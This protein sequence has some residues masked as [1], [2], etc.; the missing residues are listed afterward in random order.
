MW[1]FCRDPVFLPF[2][3]PC[4]LTPSYPVT[5]DCWSMP[6]VLCVVILSTKGSWT[7]LV[8]WAVAYPCRCS[9]IRR[10]RSMNVHKSLLCRIVSACAIP[11]ILYCSSIIFPDCSTKT[12][13]LSPSSGVA[14]SQIC[15][16]LISSCKRLSSSIINDPLHPLYS[17]L[18]NDLSTSNT[19]SSF[20]RLQ[21]RAS[22]CR[23]SLIPSMARH[24][25]NPKQEVNLLSS[26]PSWGAL[27]LS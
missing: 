26:N 23:K 12:L 19:R 3:S 14:Y 27:P 22:F 21:C 6:M 20:K 24:L 15:K 1:V 4:I 7:M 8:F 25:V 18:G 5:T 2:Y 11:A 17:W 10:R 16:V 13:P 9:F